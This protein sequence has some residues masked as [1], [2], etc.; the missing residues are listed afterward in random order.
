MIHARTKT[1]G[2]LSC[3]I[4]V[5]TGI[6]IV[7][8]ALATPLPPAAGLMLTFPAL[9]GLA[10]YFS[11]DARAAAIA[12]TMFW[13]PVVNGAL[14]AG[15][16]V[17]VLLLATAVPPTALGWGL[18]LIA[19]ALWFA[20]VTRRHVRAGIDLSRQSAFAIAATLAGILL[21]A[22]TML[23]I[24]RWGIS[25]PAA[26]FASN[27]ADGG[28]I[29]AAIVHGRLKIALF[30]LTL[31]VLVLAI[32]F[33]PISDSTRGILAGLPIVPFGGLV[34]IASDF[35]LSADARVQIFRGMIAGVWL[36]PAVAIWYIFY[37][38]R[39][40]IARR[41][42]GTMAAD[43]LWRFGALLLAWL[44][45]FAVFVAIAYALSALGYSARARSAG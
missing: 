29:V 42:A 19:A 22:V 16:L 8:V 36:G 44:V 6:Y 17:L 1:L 28:G 11:E 33:V 10:F 15:Y 37:F 45:T 39:F 31:A 24:T 5:G 43:A 18:L 13:M 20:W 32:H 7:I 23:V 41:P 34:S 14:C 27:P 38:S 4:V 40:L 26:V 12:R 3:R 9:N 2:R 21:A 30:A 35:S 25:S